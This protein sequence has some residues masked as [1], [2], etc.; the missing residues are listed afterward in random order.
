MR[1][2]MRGGARTQAGCCA[3]VEHSRHHRTHSWLGTP[4][5]PQVARRTAAAV[6]QPGN[7][8]LHLLCHPPACLA[9][10]RMHDLKRGLQGKHNRRAL[11]PLPAVNA[12]GTQV[13]GRA[14]AGA[15]LLLPLHLVP[16]QYLGR[17]SSVQQVLERMPTRIP[18][19]FFQADVSDRCRARCARQ[20]LSPAALPTPLFSL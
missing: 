1:H 20:L 4:E 10:L 9:V 7:V 8:T 2:S 15:P 3:D 14:S 12:R 16:L 13:Q 11:P 18:L 6:A 5:L 17:A 19:H